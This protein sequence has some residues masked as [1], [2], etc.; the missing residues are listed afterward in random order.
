MIKDY[1]VYDSE[2]FSNESG[3]EHIPSSYVNEI[4]R[5]DGPAPE[6]NDLATLGLW[7]SSAVDITDISQVSVY[8]NRGI[9]GR[10]WTGSSSYGT[11]SYLPE[12]IFDLLQNPEYGLG[13]IIG[14]RGVD[15]GEMSRT[16]RYC[17]ANDFFW[18][19]VIKDRVNIR[20]WIFEQAGV[21]H[22]RL[23]HPRRQ[24]LYQTKFSLS[25]AI[26]GFTTTVT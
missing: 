6:Y 4:R 9:T 14:R 1:A 5:P 23:L 21:H 10:T 2:S 22:V 13:G 20:Q 25:T 24:V 19:G 15:E 7:I 11:I 8:V 12:I 3:P 18:D 26:T 17:R 16:T